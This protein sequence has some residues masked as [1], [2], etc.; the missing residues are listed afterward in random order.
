MDDL[1]RVIEQAE[2]AVGCYSVP[3][4]REAVATAVRSY[5]LSKERVLP[6]DVTVHPATTFKAGVKLSTLLDCIEDRRAMLEGHDD[7]R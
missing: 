2:L 4:V 5:L 6:C 3:S 7:G 1:E